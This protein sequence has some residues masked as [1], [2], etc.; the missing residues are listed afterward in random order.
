M[1][2]DCPWLLLFVPWLNWLSSFIITELLFS[3]QSHLW[4][5]SPGCLWVLVVVPGSIGLF[6]IRTFIMVCFY[7]VPLAASDLLI[8]PGCLWL[9]LAE[10]V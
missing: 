4:L 7:Q 9:P 1:V 2:S 3:G 10:L 8:A 6:Y 5:L